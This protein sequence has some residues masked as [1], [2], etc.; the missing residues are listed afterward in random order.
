M[1]S[2]AILATSPTLSVS[3]ATYG[4]FLQIENKPAHNST[5]TNESAISWMLVAVATL[6][7]IASLVVRTRILSY[8]SPFPSDRTGAD[9]TMLRNSHPN[10]RHDRSAP[11]TLSLWLYPPQDARSSIQDQID[12]LATERGPSF[13]PHVTLV[14]NIP[15][16]SEEQALQLGRALQDG[17]RGFGTVPCQ[18]SSTPKTSEGVWSQALYLTMTEIDPFL[19]LC[20]R[21]RVLLGLELPCT[22]APPAHQPHMSLFYGVTDIPNASEVEPVK[23]FDASTIAI[24]TIGP[25]TLASVPNWKEVSVIQLE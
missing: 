5:E 4:S 12:I 10:L 2:E 6:T 7:C 22:F 23:S 11:I 14:G 3:R 20:E 19:K 13:T 18:F 17:L 8:N 24:W 25:S 21:C 1:N 15:C 16:Q 9:I